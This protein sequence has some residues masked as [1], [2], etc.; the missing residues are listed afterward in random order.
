M[1][2]DEYAVVRAL[3]DNPIPDSKLGRPQ[4]FVTANHTQVLAVEYYRLEK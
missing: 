2:E 3:L 1:G 4:W